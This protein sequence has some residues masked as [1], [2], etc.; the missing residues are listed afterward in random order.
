MA[1]VAFSMQEIEENETPED[2]S[3]VTQEVVSKLSSK[4]RP[5]NTE[6]FLKVLKGFKLSTDIGEK[7]TVEWLPIIALRINDT[8]QREVRENGRSNV[9]QIAKNFKWQKFGVVLVAATG[10]GTFAVIDGQHRT[11]G[12][13]IR[14]IDAVPCLIL[15]GVS[16]E[17]QADIFAA[18][19]G[20]VTSI[21]PLAIFHA[22]L[23]SKD[24]TAIMINDLC[25]E[26]G[27]TI[28]RYVK[29]HTHLMRGETVSINTLK[30]MLRNYERKIVLLSL[31]C[32]LKASGEHTTLLNSNVIKAM[33]QTLESEGTFRVPEYRLISMMERFDLYKEWQAAHEDAK[34]KRKFVAGALSVRIFKYLDNELN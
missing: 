29:P 1:A 34:T 23:A 19:N 13:A 25:K 10:D 15:Y 14:G 32:I 6:P 4:L 22:E 26:A 3:E 18:I 12:A 31:K 11:L 8:Y 33:C 9:I 21:S 16:V 30:E 2:D 17:Q 7:P 27:V 28:C 20:K 5:I 24:P